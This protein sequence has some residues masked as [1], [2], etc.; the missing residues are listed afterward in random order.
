MTGTWHIISVCLGTSRSWWQFCAKTTCRSTRPSTVRRRCISKNGPAHGSS[1]PTFPATPPRSA[2]D[3]AKKA[4]LTQPPNIK[5]ANFI[6]PRAHTS[7]CLCD[8]I[9]TVQ[10][11]MHLKINCYLSRLCLLTHGLLLFAIVKGQCS[12]RSCE[13]R[14]FPRK[15]HESARE[16]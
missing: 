16:I 8:F 14:R 4:N 2:D 1:V 5:A 11:V 9:R 15:V 13:M 10:N 3:G 12:K 7:A 6:T